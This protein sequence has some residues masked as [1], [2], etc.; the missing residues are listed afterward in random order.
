MIRP[1]L[2]LAVAFILARPLGAAPAASISDAAILTPPAPRSP[3]IN[4]P[5]VFGVRPASPFLYTI[6]ATGD[7]PMQFAAEG[8]PGGL[9]IAA[10][11][12]QIS[13]SVANAGK[14][15][16]SLIASNALGTA[17]KRLRIVVGES[18][19]LT[20]AMGWNSWNCW[21]EAVN[22]ERV[23]ES[24]RAMVSSGLINHGWTY[25]NID[26]TWQGDRSGP[27]H[28][29]QGNAKFPDMKALCD[30]IHGI[31][32]K[33]GIYSTPWVTSYAK[34][35]GG[36]S[37]SPS[38]AW[39]RSLA[40][41]ANW[42]HGAHAFARADARQWALWGF[43]YLKYDWNP[44]DLA[45]VEEMSRALRASGRDIVFSLSNTA[46]YEIAAGLARLANSWRTTS[47]IRDRWVAEG[48]S[49]QYGVSEIGFS[50]DRWAAYAGPGHWNDPDML[51]V[52]RVGWGN[53][54][55]AQLTAD[56]QYSHISLWCLLSAPL[57]IGCDLG[58]LDPFT[59][60]LLTNDE[61]LALDQD[62]LGRQAVRVATA[63]GID[64]YMKELED[65]SRALGFFNRESS[66]QTLSF[67]KLGYL[68]FS[69]RQHVRDLWRQKDL[70]DVVNPQRDSLTVTMPAHGVIL[71]RLTPVG[72]AS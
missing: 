4:G 23:M 29:L 32:L 1:A 56:E 28:A 14:Y 10:A 12:G 36:S 51:V 62:A 60:N 15:E 26:D 66:A 11:T 54:K 72:P 44:N 34:F 71:C 41:E 39:D 53:P 63:G 6:Q 50:Q 46:P 45:H 58:K 20:P 17:Q 2:F 64:V 3:R 38:G 13:G 18:I 70:P 68:G 25:V 40:S 35:P 7:R 30:A 27:D 37:D 48:Q 9:S 55:P 22:Q 16:V 19:A 49:W 43:D 57:L 33:A 24:A 69:K 67:N 47:D 65:G 52:G 31:G 8:L 21:A 61:V 59:L 42:R 5:T